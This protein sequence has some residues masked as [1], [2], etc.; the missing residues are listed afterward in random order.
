M[1]VINEAMGAV[2]NLDMACASVRAHV[3]DLIAEIDGLKD[4]IRILADQRDELQQ[5]VKEL[6]K[7]P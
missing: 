4:V 1:S 3:D 5:R 2:E 7:K 6:E